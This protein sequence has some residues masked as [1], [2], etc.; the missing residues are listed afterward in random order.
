MTVSNLLSCTCYIGHKQH[1]LPVREQNWQRTLQNG[2]M[3][4]AFWHQ[5]QHH[6]SCWTE[7]EMISPSDENLRFQNFSCSTLGQTWDFLKFVYENKTA[8]ENKHIL[9][10]NSQESAGQGTEVVCGRPKFKSL[11]Y[12]SQNISLQSHLPAS[13]KGTKTILPPKFCYFS[14]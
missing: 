12:L 5:H 8:S 10:Q 7:W 3:T 14:F 4:F 11:L 6:V 13:F 1:S 9:P 2:G